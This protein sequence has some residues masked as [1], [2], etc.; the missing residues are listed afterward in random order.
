M[1]RTVLLVLCTVT[2]LVGGL[3]YIRLAPSPTDQWHVAI[4]GDSDLDF[5]GG[6]VR[7]LSAPVGALARVDRAAKTLPRT[8]LLAGSVESGR[9]TY[10]T[11]SKGFGF[12]DYTT[13]EQTD[14]GLKFHARL[15]FG[16]SDFGVNR[17][18]VRQLIAA[19]Q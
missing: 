19:L 4:E 18:R 1:K 15:R 12:P 14:T 6:V 2:L 10:V 8:K 13:V 7:V 16:R 3:G 17:D 11:R 5:P 9:I